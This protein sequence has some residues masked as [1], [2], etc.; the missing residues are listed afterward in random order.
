MCWS[1]CY[2][3]WLFSKFKNLI[4]ITSYPTAAL[5]SSSRWKLSLRSGWFR[6]QNWG[7]L[8]PKLA[9]NEDL[10]WFPIDV[11]T[12]KTTATEGRRKICYTN[13]A[14]SMRQA[15][16]QKTS[17]SDLGG[18]APART[19][20]HLKTWHRVLYW[21]R[22]V[23]VVPHWVTMSVFGG[24]CGTISGHSTTLQHQEPIQMLH[25]SQI[26]AASRITT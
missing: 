22:T 7:S 2:I 18:S 19:P 5:M 1:T 24:C 23:V 25:F 6:G 20:G 8:A 4:L 26:Y 14:N 15:H 16:L 10:N 13:N 12:T 11:K 21:I 17:S 9:N 3:H